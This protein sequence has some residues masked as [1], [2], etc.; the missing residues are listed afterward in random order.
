[1]GVLE[2]ENLSFA[3]RARSFPRYE[4]ERI[5]KILRRNRGSGGGGDGNLGDRK[6]V[7]VEKADRSLR[8]EKEM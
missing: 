5:G 2:R 4:E 3:E 6:L 8:D 1:M 7:V